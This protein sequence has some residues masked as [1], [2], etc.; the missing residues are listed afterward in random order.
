MNKKTIVFVCLLLSALYVSAQSNIDFFEGTYSDALTKAKNEDKMIFI[1]IYADWCGPCKRMAKD[2]FTDSNVAEYYNNSF[3]SLS[4]NPEKEI[5]HP[6]VKGR[7]IA[8]FPS[9]YWL[10]SDGEI[11]LVAEGYLTPDELIGKGKES[12][13]ANLSEEYNKYKSLWINGERTPENVKGFINSLRIFEPG[14]VVATL[15]E[16][17]DGL[18]ADELIKEEN[19]PFIME[20]GY[21]EQMS[22]GLGI[23][24]LID[25]YDEYKK[26]EQP[27]V[28]ENNLYKMIVRTASALRNV[29]PK[30]V[31]FIEKIDSIFDD[32]FVIYRE[33]IDVERLLFEKQYLSGIKK[34]ID[35]AEKYN[36]SWI[37]S[38]IAYTLIISEYF[39]SELDEDTNKIVV[40][41][42]KKALKDYPSKETLMYL[43]IAY[44]HQKEYDKS[45]ELLAN[46]NLYPSPQLS[47]AVYRLLNLNVIR[48]E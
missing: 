48:P 14:K 33:L 46:Q 1:D 37:Y 25:N 21:I 11:Q 7:N 47:N 22:P 38:E 23:G 29:P 13:N 9:F 4:I 44:A 28:L 42:T 26:Y 30:D 39:L 32:Q 41:M 35:L 12:K 43:A 16:Y 45:Y 6:F 27:G 19:Y 34:A 20:L 2:V 24:L 18:S 15:K 10:S 17:I 3:I 40:E 8:A 31:V 36:S 5:D